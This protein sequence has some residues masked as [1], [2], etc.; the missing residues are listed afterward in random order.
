MSMHVRARESIRTRF[1]PY[2][3][4][5]P[6]DLCLAGPIQGVDLHTEGVSVI[7]GDTH[8]RR[9]SKSALW[10]A[11]MPLVNSHLERAGWR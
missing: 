8:T 6:G 1:C 5:L 11:C 4:A 3:V 10:P 2:S 9:T 7:L